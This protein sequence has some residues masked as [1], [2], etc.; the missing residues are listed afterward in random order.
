MFVFRSKR[1][2]RCAWRREFG[3][4]TA[5]DAG[6]AE[7]DFVPVVAATDVDAAIEIE[8][9]EHRLHHRRQAIGAAP[10]IN[11]TRAIGTRTPAGGAHGEGGDHRI[12]FNRRSSL[13]RTPSSTPVLTRTIALPCDGTGLVPIWKRL[14]RARFKWP[15]ISDGVMRLSAAPTTHR[16]APA[17]DADLAGSERSPPSP[18]RSSVARVPVSTRVPSNFAN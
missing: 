6:T 16:D 12:A 2:D 5:A 14:E 9:P 1:A 8:I 11:R 7:P 3:A 18:H 4:M 10:E 17:A 15:A 13:P